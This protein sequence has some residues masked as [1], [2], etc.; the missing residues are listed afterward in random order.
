[1]Y[2]WRERSAK[3]QNVK[4]PWT[5]IWLEVL[6]CQIN[7]PHLLCSDLLIQREKRLM[8]VGQAHAGTHY[9]P[10]KSILPT[11]ICLPVFRENWALQDNL[12]KQLNELIGQVSRHEGFH[13]HR[14]LLRILG[15]WQR[16]LN[17]LWQQ[18]SIFRS[19]TEFSLNLNAILINL[20]SIHG[21]PRPSF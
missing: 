13:R 2:T 3:I 19:D 4:P 5:Q 21:R 18:A 7:S 11:Y 14:D 9:C 15:F 1:M 6:T 16:C 10:T 8:T 20:A 12:L 17:N